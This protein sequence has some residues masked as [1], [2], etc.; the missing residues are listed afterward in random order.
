MAERF[1]RHR[2]DADAAE[3]RNRPA[4]GV[5]LGIRWAFI[6][7]CVAVWGGVAWLLMG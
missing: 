3:P 2:A 4:A 6:L 1:A 5:K 7:F